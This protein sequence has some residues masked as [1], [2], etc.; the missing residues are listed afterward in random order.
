[1]CLLLGIMHVLSC[2]RCYDS[3]RSSRSQTQRIDFSGAA[4]ILL[5]ILLLH[6]ESRTS[7]PP[8]LKGH[9]YYYSEGPTLPFVCLSVSQG[10]YLWANTLCCEFGN[11]TLPFLTL[12]T[13][14][15]IHSFLSLSV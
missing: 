3:N 5:I 9:R 14:T 11:V 1:M 2:R 6:I 13:H 15:H 4:L 7:P 8:R 12:N 10:I